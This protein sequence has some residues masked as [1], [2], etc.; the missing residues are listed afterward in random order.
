MWLGA[1]SW[2]GFNGEKE[3]IMGKKRKLNTSKTPLTLAEC[4]ELP[5]WL[6]PPYPAPCRSLRHPQ[7]HITTK[8]L[9]TLD[10]GN[11]PIDV[12][13]SLPNKSS[14]ALLL[15]LELKPCR[16]VPRCPLLFPAAPVPALL[17]ILPQALFCKDTSSRPC[18]DPSAVFNTV[19]PSIPTVDMLYLNFL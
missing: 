13:V 12:F 4:L 10:T 1:G 11:R 19:R 15:P 17:S 8:L 7:A 16:L 5:L 6:P 14:I 3:E 9:T 2:Q 18:L